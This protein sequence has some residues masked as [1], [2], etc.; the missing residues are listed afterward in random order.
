MFYILVCVLLD[1]YFMIYL[2][3]TYFMKKDNSYLSSC[4]RKNN[5]LMYVYIWMCLFIEIFG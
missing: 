3:L 4:H 1:V 5:N 2:E